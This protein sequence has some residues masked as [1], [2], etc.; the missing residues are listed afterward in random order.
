MSYFSGLIL[1]FFDLLLEDINLRV[2]TGK[3]ADNKPVCLFQNVID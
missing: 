3:D 2:K 1:Q